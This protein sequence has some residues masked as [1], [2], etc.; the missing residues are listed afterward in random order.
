MSALYPADARRLG[1]GGRVRLLCVIIAHLERLRGC[2]VL[3]EEP[4]GHGF[5]TAALQ[6][7]DGYRVSAPRAGGR[8]IEGV[9]FQ[10]QID[11]RMQA[12]ANGTLHRTAAVEAPPPT[13]TTPAVAPA[14]PKTTKSLDT[15]GL[16]I[17]FALIVLGAIPTAVFW[18]GPEARARR[19]AGEYA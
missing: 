18:P 2:R 19:R 4:Q 12:A 6:V 1:I 17:F 9:S 15:L 5:A 7:A 3:E 16:P 14:R 10:L 13:L 11:F 8:P